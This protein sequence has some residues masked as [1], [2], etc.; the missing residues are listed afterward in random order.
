MRKKISFLAQLFLSFL[1]FFVVV[2]PLFML[3]NAK[4]EPLRLMDYLQVLQHGLSLDCTMAA[5]LTA[6]P[7]ILLLGTVWFS[8]I[9]FRRMLRPYYFIISFAIALIAVVDTSL[10][11][12]WHFKLDATVFFYLE[13]PTDAIASVSWG[14][15]LIR[16]LVILAITGGFGYLLVRIT[17]LH[18]AKEHLRKG[19]ESTKKQRIVQPIAASFLLLF[20]MGLLFLTI[21]GGWK[22]STSNVGQVYFS[23]RQ[24]LNH[25]AINPAFNL[26]SS[27][28]KSK[29]FNQEYNLL[30]ESERQKWYA[31]LYKAVPDSTQSWLK[32]KRPNVLLLVFE[33][34]GAGFVEAVG[35]EANIT[36]NYNQLAKEGI[37]FKNCYANS[38]RTDRGMVCALSGHLGYP[39]TSIMKIPAKSRNLPSIAK[40]L[41][42]EGYATHFLYGGDINFTNM[43]SYL[44]STG[45]QQVTGDTSFPI[46]LQ[47]SS[48]WGVHDEFTFHKLYND[49]CARKDSLW[50]ETF[51][52]L[53]SHE[54]FEVPYQRLKAKIPNAVAYTDHCFG[55][56]IAKLKQTPAW[57]NLLIICVSDHGY[58]YP[59]TESSTHPRYFHI[60]QLWLGGA[61]KAPQEIHKIVNQ[62]D[63]AA[64]LLSQLGLDHSDFIYSRNVS[65]KGYTHPFAYYAFND[66]FGFI[67]PTGATTFDNKGN[68][69]IFDQPADSCSTKRL[70]RGKAIQQT[71]YDN[72]S[73]R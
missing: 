45:Y 17:P 40:K 52:T 50:F 20:V 73:K 26:L 24:F 68:C 11:D 58:Y 23:N 2:K 27:M 12:F 37:L 71:S 31:P 53:S 36:P 39:N 42:A 6:I 5:Y 62:S 25:A 7:C 28:E 18:F 49:I 33:S 67:D 70:L 15:L 13:S 34:F 41:V 38:F 63:I 22:E 72:L 9:P 32:S 4:E 54:P 69:V 16:L 65:N 64:T 46:A 60:P 29:D 30:S 10:Y 35:G 21:R 61:I 43:K 48:K 14:F 19:Q 47:E 1:A 59:R 8:R 51:L 66:G 56:F 44:L 3:Y 57:D 55:E